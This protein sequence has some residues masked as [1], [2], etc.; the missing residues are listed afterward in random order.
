MASTSDLTQ[1]TDILAKSFHSPQ[2]FWGWAYP[3]LRLGIYEDLH[4]RLQTPS[5]N[6]LCL[7]AVD[8]TPGQGQ[9]LTGT[10]EIGLRS[11]DPWSGVKRF[12]YLSNL[13]V[14][15]NYRRRG[16]AKSLLLSCEQ[17]CQDW[18]FQ[19]L[20]LH[21]LEHNY[22]ARQL[23]LNLGYKIFQIESPWSTFLFQRPRQMFLHKYLKVEP[24]V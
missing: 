8:R 11:T 16:V 3:L 4:N 7:V 1:I 22:Q 17:I 14:H 15:P 13:A 18:G 20:Y 21:V 19:D 23:Y 10:V 6:Q 12:P 9:N 24:P 5:P 2:G